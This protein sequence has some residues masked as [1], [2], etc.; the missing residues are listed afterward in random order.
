MVDIFTD[1]KNLSRGVERE[2]AN[3]S[4]DYM[5]SLEMNDADMHAQARTV[6]GLPVFKFLY[7]AIVA[8][9][10]WA[11]AKDSDSR[12]SDLVLRGT[13]NGVSLFKER[14]ERMASMA[15]K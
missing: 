2:H 8:D 5:E 7:D 13:L 10:L 4:P 12:E 14:M 9:C 6:C 3:M 15:K 11:V 1:R